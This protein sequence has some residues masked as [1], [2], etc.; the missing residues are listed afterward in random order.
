MLIIW[1]LNT[2]P[3]AGA[4]ST[5]ARSATESRSAGSV[6]KVMGI[7]TLRGGGSGRSQGCVG[8][9]AGRLLGVLGPQHP[10]GADERRP[11]S[12]GV[13]HV[14]DE[15]AFGRVVGVHQ[16]GLVVLDHRGT[17]GL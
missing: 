9:L 17:R 1:S 14:V 6:V 10:E 16:L 13:D 5:R 11:G 4:S 8:M 7:R 15:A 3:N 12:G 2:S